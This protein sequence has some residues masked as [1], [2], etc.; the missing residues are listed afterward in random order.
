[1]ENVIDQNLAKECGLQEHDLHVDPIE[2]VE[3]EHIEIY[4]VFAA[5]IEV[6]D[7]RRLTRAD[8][9]LFVA[10]DNPS[11]QI[12]LGY[13][14][15]EDVDPLISFRNRTWW[16]A[17]TSPTT[18]SV[19]SPKEFY[20]ACAEEGSTPVMV[21]C[22]RGYESG[23][24]LSYVQGNKSRITQI[25]SIST[26]DTGTVTLPE[27]YREFTDLCNDE[28]AGQLPEH[29]K[30]EHRIEL[31]EGAVL[32]WG[33]IY[34]LSDMELQVLRDYLEKAQRNGWIRRSTSPAGA[35]VMFVPKKDGGLRLCVD[36]RGLNRI[37][38]KDRTPLPLISET[39]DRLSNADIFTKLDLKDAYHRIRIRTGDEHKTAFRTRYGHFE[40][41]VVPFGLTNAPATFQ[42]YIN[43]ALVGLVDVTCVVY[44]DDILIYTTKGED[45]ETAVKEVMG[46]LRTYK[47]YINLKKC[48][49][50]V[51]TVTFLGFVISP[52]GVEMEAERVRTVSEWPEPKT[53]RD[54][55][56]F[57]GFA[58][59]Y[60]RF[61]KG[62]SR[63]TAGLTNMLKTSSKKPSEP[64]KLTEHA[65]MNF[66]EMKAR[67]CSAPVL[68]HFR[69]D[70]PIMVETDA[71]QFAVGAVLSQLFSGDGTDAWHP[72]AFFSKKLSDVESRYD[73]H[74][75]ELMAIVL[76]FRHWSHYLRHVQDQVTVKTDH[77]GL[78][79]F[80]T[81]PKLNARQARWAEELCAYDFKVEYR[82]GR[83]NPADGPSRRPDYKGA[84]DEKEDLLPLLRMKFSLIASLLLSGPDE[85]PGKH[86]AVLEQIGCKH[87][88]KD[89]RSSQPLPVKRSVCD[90]R[91]ARA[92]RLSRDVSVRA[93]EVSQVNA[94][95]GAIDRELCGPWDRGCR[96]PGSQTVYDELDQPMLD[97][98]HDLQLKDAFAKSDEWKSS[99]SRAGV[100][101]GW[102][103][104]GDGLLR[105]NGTVYVPPVVALREELLRQC[106]DDPI[107]GH[108]GFSK[109][110]E[111]LR[112]YYY[113]D[114]M[115]K[116]VKEWVRRCDTCQRVKARRHK[117]YGKL[118]ML[119]VPKTPWEEISCDFI[120]G[121]PSSKDHLGNVYD[122]V[123]V[124]ICRFTKMA[125]YIPVRKTITAAHLADVFL[126]VIVKDFGL[127][128]GIVSDRGS[129]FT[130]NFWSSLCFLLKIRRRLST[131]FHPQTDGQ[132]ER[133][134]QNIEQ[135]LRAYSTYRGDDW[136]SKLPLAEFAYN[137]A[138]HSSIKDT[139][140]HATYGFHP[141]TPSS[142]VGDDKP[143]GEA[144][145]VPSA[146]RRVE[147]GEEQFGVRGR[148]RGRKEGGNE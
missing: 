88:Q 73:T 71:S 97:F 37:T 135:Y 64:F 98:I 12:I 114:S 142:F 138:W 32:P 95:T 44:L 132:T 104:Q 25:L 124:V 24:R 45:H 92:Q 54:I 130:S 28:A 31:E 16:F 17:D 8:E 57:L 19:L 42:A 55:Q 66:E 7:T 62:Y 121:L 103:R 147:G 58:G 6:T 112:R 14:W 40:Y 23:P 143:R 133:Q 146:E 123:F 101:A 87:F 72:I 1:M 11:S 69:A 76:A 118:G 5:E 129:V 13:P 36:Y 80:M 83:T 90:V 116:D 100:S 33:P 89:R 61:I 84:D 38:K 109:T 107:A 2:S 144:P 65:R 39:L 75:G 99:G 82:Q 4:G 51:D 29:H 85:A 139:P 96:P 59:F 50:R 134:N 131:A 22:Q 53:I 60:R 102:E 110:Y 137:N 20:K 105:K 145:A 141:R 43:Q 81:K 94:V 117:P 119:P 125:K 49:F 18:I 3:R 30:M 78:K 34:N 91:N 35:P 106:H 15:L 77:H 79:S 93:R 111:L 127:P 113:W 140:F 63:H 86:R 136:C 9:H 68:R 10:M 108:F 46:R 21:H 120:T 67:F 27:A 115:R 47:L 70:L 148:G 56:T 26:K 41:C 126:A 52:R 74:D 48:A 128:K 122:A